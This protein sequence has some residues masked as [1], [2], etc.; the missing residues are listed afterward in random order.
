MT[1]PLARE[2]ASEK[3]QGTK[4]RWVTLRGCRGRYGDLPAARRLKRLD[5]S[6]FR[7]WFAARAIEHGGENDRT[8]Q[9][10]RKLA[11]RCRQHESIERTWARPATRQRE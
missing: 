3:R 7:D 11:V 9:F 2:P 1:H 8:E 6:D 5:R 4:S 10:V